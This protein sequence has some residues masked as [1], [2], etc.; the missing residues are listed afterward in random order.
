P[1]LDVRLAGNGEEDHVALVAELFDQAASAKPSSFQVVG[2]DEVKPAADKCVGIYGDDWN[3]FLNGQIDL[4]LQDRLLQSI[5]FAQRIITLRPDNLGR[6]FV[7]RCRFVESVCY[8]LPV[9]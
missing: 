5:Q 1:L 9:R 2:S 8:R 3:S 7:L 4:P 6:H